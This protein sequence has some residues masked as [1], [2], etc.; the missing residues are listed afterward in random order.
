MVQTAPFDEPLRQVQSRDKDDVSTLLNDVKRY[1]GQHKSA[2]P[3]L[4]QVARAVGRSESVLG[5][6]YPE[7]CDKIISATAKSRERAEAIRHAERD[8]RLRSVH[9]LCR[10]VGIDPSDRHLRSLDGMPST[11]LRR[12]ELKPLLREAR[13]QLDA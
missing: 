5:Y 10:S 1:L 11:D 6:R 4:K 12:P 13:S 9:E 8:S 7:L 3:S 2:H